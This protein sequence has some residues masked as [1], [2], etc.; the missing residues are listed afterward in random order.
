MAK[1][2]FQDSYYGRLV[3]E[4]EKVTV[5]GNKAT[6]S[7]KDSDGKPYTNY[8]KRTKDGWR[9]NGYSGS[10]GQV[11]SS[12]PKYIRNKNTTRPDNKEQQKKYLGNRGK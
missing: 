7:G 9:F 1:E 3:Y 6:V 12:K 11:K 8:F 5:N 2:S 4:N 10:N